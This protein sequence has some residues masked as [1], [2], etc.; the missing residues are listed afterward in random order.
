MHC[1][2]D[3]AIKYVVVY[4]SNTEAASRAPHVRHRHFTRWVNAN[5]SDWALFRVLENRYR[6]DPG[7]EDADHS[8]CDFYFYKRVL[9]N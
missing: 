9:V 3:S 2:F 6:A 7:A 4:S 5:R 1:L 8:F